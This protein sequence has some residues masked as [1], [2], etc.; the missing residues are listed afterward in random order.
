MY[1]LVET[2]M[3]RLGKVGM[4]QGVLLSPLPRQH[5]AL[6][7]IKSHE[8][9]WEFYLILSSWDWNIKRLDI[10]MH[11]HMVSLL[12]LYLS[13]EDFCTFISSLFAIT[14]CV[15]IACLIQVL[16]VCRRTYMTESVGQWVS[17]KNWTIPTNCR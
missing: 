3:F 2:G 14:F 17:T 5:F 10:Y 7:P 9:I 11:Y 12:V 16:V 4:M 15:T 8:S 1:C 13:L 6:Q